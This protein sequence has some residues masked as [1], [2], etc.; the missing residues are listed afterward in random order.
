MS[1]EVE[2]R[3]E[4]DGDHAAA[5]AARC[6]R[7][8]HAWIESALVV[9]ATPGLYFAMDGCTACLV[10]QWSLKRG[11]CQIRIGALPFNMSGES[12]ILTPAV[13]G[14]VIVGLPTPSLEHN[15]QVPACGAM[16]SSL[17]PGAHH[18][19]AERCVLTNGH[20]GPHRSRAATWI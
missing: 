10:V 15:W 8:E 2:R 11:T 6:R 19:E 9:C 5:Q 14:R 12:V 4:R 1:D 3:A 18:P 13:G 17:P 16:P 7:G 20:D